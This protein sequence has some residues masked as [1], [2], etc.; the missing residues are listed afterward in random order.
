[1]LRLCQRLH[2]AVGLSA[3]LQVEPCKYLF[4]KR[5]HRYA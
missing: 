5:F 2:L 1:M 3:F 4:L